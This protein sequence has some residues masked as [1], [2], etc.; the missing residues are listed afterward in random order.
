MRP[1][2]RRTIALLRKALSD[3]E[4]MSAWIRRGRKSEI[5]TWS[6]SVTLLGGGLA[7]AS[8]GGSVSSGPLERTGSATRRKRGERSR[9]RRYQRFNRRSGELVPE[10]PAAIATAELPKPSPPRASETKLLY[11][12]FKSGRSDPAVHRTDFNTHRT[13]RGQFA[14]SEIYVEWLKSSPHYAGRHEE[15]RQ[16]Y[17]PSSAKPSPPPPAD[18][19]I[20]IGSL[21]QG[22]PYCKAERKVMHK[23]REGQGC[24][25]RF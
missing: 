19:S 12:D 13:V 8:G 22:G 9:L 15:W 11:T 10:P 3:V 14:E 25:T 21:C 24:R 6:W 20:P 5:G 23:V 18:G 2:A 1:L 17:A 4:V 7:V 16:T